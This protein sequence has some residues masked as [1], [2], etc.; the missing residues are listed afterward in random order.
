M[1]VA[2][3]A[4]LLV[5]ALLGYRP[6]HAW[7]FPP[8]LYALYWTVII[9]AALIIGYGKYTLTVETTAVFF[10]GAV[11]F[12]VGG[13]LAL[14]VLGRG[15]ASKPTGP[16][17]KQLIQTLIAV[18]S[19]GLLLLVP[20]FVRSVERAG[21]VLGVNDFAV[22]A[23]L[24]LLQPDRTNIP[25]YFSSLSS[26]GGVL[27]FYAAWLYSG[28]RRDKVVL[29]LA[30]FAPLI[31]Y[32]LTF[33]R[34]PVYALAVGILAILVFRKTIRLQTATLGLIGAL[35]VALAMGSS[36]SKGPD[37][38]SGQSPVEAI[39]E[40]LAVYYIGG[41]LGFGQVMDNPQTVGQQGLSLRFFTQ[42]AQSAGMDIEIPNNIL[43]YVADD[44]GN[45]YTFYFA[46]WLDWGWWGIIVVSALAGFVST[47]VYVLARRGSAIAGAALGMVV[48]SI[49]NS[50]TGDGLFGSAMPWLL[51]ISVG[52][53]L[54]HMPL[55][56]RR[57][58]VPGKRTEL[59]SLA[60]T[61]RE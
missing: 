47:A 30:V 13:L 51:T 6:F 38:Q 41:P 33:S 9:A 58:R 25:R 28:T 16:E 10:I 15:A 1:I 24:A 2:I 61:G 46:Y 29:A 14:V 4:A 8:G 42:T 17:R 19:I 20:L 50:A 11:C 43:G 54:W 31:M 52:W 26:L 7:L 21:L 57:A 53:L 55:I 35:I 37:F 3:L 56:G 27:A 23:R 32:V 59:R 60:S 48:G 22:A 39:V 44:L 5:L 40:N 34:S 12:S 45:V 18:Y 49:L 36:L